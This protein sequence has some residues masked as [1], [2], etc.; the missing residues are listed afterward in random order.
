MTSMLTEL[1]KNESTMFCRVSVTFIVGKS[2]S[3]GS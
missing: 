3:H 2:G 1:Y